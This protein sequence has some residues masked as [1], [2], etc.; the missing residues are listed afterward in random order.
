M[1]RQ[2]RMQKGVSKVLMCGMM[3][4]KVAVLCLVNTLADLPVNVRLD[5]TVRI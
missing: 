5:A 3:L 4:E 2:R 1:L